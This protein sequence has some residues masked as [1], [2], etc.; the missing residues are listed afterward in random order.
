MTQP[1]DPHC[2]GRVIADPIAPAFHLRQE[3][4]SI[5]ALLPYPGGRVLHITQ[6]VMAGN[7]VTMLG[8]CPASEVAPETISYRQ[9]I[10]SPVIAA[11]V[12]ALQCLLRTEAAR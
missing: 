4:I 5:I 7:R 10:R 1:P 12:D 9:D 2:P 6:I 3:L 11:V 8:I